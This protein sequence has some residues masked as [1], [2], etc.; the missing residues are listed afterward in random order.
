M[1]RFV[2]KANEEPTIGR[3][4]PIRAVGRTLACATLVVAGVGPTLAL[5]TWPRV[6]QISTGVADPSALAIVAFQ[7]VTVAVMAAIPFAMKR[8][9]NCLQK[10]GFLV[11]GLV[12][13]A[14]N[15]GAAT[16]AASHLRD[17]YADPRRA[18]ITR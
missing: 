2:V 10:M 16:E 4:H 14:L 15:W 8:A 11:L 12:L 6:S 5:N 17:A 3:R 7:A 13:A 9:D 18:T 1:E